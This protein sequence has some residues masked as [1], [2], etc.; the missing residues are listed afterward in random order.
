[1][2]GPATQSVANTYVVMYVLTAALPTTK[3][4]ASMTTLSYRTVQYTLTGGD[5]LNTVYDRLVTALVDINY[6]ATFQGDHVFVTWQDGLL[7]VFFLEISGFNYWLVVV[8]SGDD[9]TQNDNMMTNVIT[10]I[11]RKAN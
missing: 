10:L 5:T 6:N 4:K 2:L 7:D 3:R 1:V 9:Q 8:S 11:Q